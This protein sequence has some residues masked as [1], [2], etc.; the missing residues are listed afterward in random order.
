[1]SLFYKFQLIFI[2]IQRNGTAEIQVYKS[3]EQV[4][5][6]KS[7]ET[8]KPGL[9]YTALVRDSFTLISINTHLSSIQILIVNQLNAKVK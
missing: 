6:Q 4:R 9:N 5:I 2:G 1:M 3:G 8:F 7:S